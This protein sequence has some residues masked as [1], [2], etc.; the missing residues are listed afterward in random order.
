M[1]DFNGVREDAVGDDAYF[2]VVLGIHLH[3]DFLQAFLGQEAKAEVDGAVYLCPFFYGKVD[4]DPAI[5]L[6]GVYL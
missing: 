2:T 3:D 6:L 1:Y 5:G 4:P